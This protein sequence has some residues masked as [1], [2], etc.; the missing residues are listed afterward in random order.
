LVR[1]RQIVAVHDRRE[2]K[3]RGYHPPIV[4]ASLYDGQR[5]NAAEPTS[6]EPEAD[7]ADG[8]N[9][10]DTVGRRGVDLRTG[11]LMRNAKIGRRDAA[12]C[13]GRPLR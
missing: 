10:E 9:P 12:S 4:T 11:W 13:G 1:C 6:P 8:G 7:A 5:H 3:R 2:R